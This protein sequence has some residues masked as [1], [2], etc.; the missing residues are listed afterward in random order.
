MILEKLIQTV[1]GTSDNKSLK[2]AEKHFLLKL[3]GEKNF[4]VNH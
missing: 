4:K 2:Q 3:I 1:T